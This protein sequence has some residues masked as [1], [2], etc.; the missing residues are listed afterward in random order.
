MSNQ[1]RIVV[2]A[3]SNANGAT[4]EAEIHDFG[5]VGDG[6]T[7]D[8]AAFKKAFAY[9]DG[10]GGTLY[11]PEGIYCLHEE[12]TVPEGVTLLGDFRQ[13]TPEDPRAGGTILALY[14]RSCSEGNTTPFFTLM[15]AASLNGL[16]L[17]YPEQAF[18][19]GQ[20]TAYPYTVQT[21]FFPAALEN[22]YLVNAYDGI[23]QEVPGDYTIQQMVRGIY[24]TP[25]HKGF[26]FNRAPDSCR[27][28][29]F[30]FRP[31]WWLGCGLP[32]VPEEKVLRGWLLENAVGFDLGA[33]DWHFISDITIQG[34]CIGMRLSSAFGR[35]YNLDITGCR[36]CLEV[37]SVVPYGGQLTCAVLRADGGSDP[38]ALHIR[39]AR[40]ENGFSCHAVT[41]ESTGRYAVVMEDKAYL[42]L[43]DSSVKAAAGIHNKEGRFTACGTVFACTDRTADFGPAAGRC[44]LTNCTDGA[45][46]PL[47]QPD[48]GRMEAVFD[49]EN[50][51][52]R[53]D[54]EALRRTDA[55]RRVR[56]GFPVTRCLIPAAEYG[57]LPDGSDVGAAL[58]AALD[59]ARDAGGGVVY[60]PAGVYRLES[61]VTVPSGVELRGATGHYHYVM[62]RCTYFLTDYGR[63][64]DTLP[65]LFTL[66]SGSGLRGI[67]VSYDKV[68]Q[69]TIQPYA[70][71]I[72]GRGSD[73]SVIG[74]SVAAAWFVADFNT[75]RCDNHYIDSL[76]FVAFHMGIAVGGGSENGV[77]LNGH[78]NPGEVWD[79]P[80]TERQNWSP[81]WDGP[82]ITHLTS[83]VTG[84]YVGETKNEVLY[85]TFIFGTKHGIH[86]D[87]GADV[88]VIGHGTDFSAHGVYLTGNS[89]S[90]IV[91][92]E[93]VGIYTTGDAQSNGV[94]A[95]ADFTGEAELFNVCPWNVHDAAVRVKNGTVRANGGV[96]FQ[97]G[98]YAVMVEKG[99]AVLSGAV[100][101]RC[102][103]GRFWASGEESTICAF[104]N[105]F[106]SHCCQ[107]EK[108]A[109]AI[110]SDIAGG[111]G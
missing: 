35:V 104:G 38:V 6:R 66:E 14:T 18:T 32:G 43:Q 100:L 39:G 45:G 31:D 47:V 34:Y 1:L 102:N 81:L 72:Q 30:D 9:M 69:E 40:E 82:L 91:D 76:N 97:S 56:T 83:H 65:A 92:A 80:F 98:D 79:N 53:L 10:C 20:P 48:N 84:F 23:N 96:F 77:V 25:L 44:R 15:G 63:G 27:Q 24:G 33:I 73:I 61:P 21:T 110:G 88:T 105:L 75:F 62:G 86:I 89:R 103:C 95:D 70:T 78:S 36:T 46:Q 12:L 28:H 109:R 29:G 2:S 94:L 106:I 49:P 3:Y 85:M 55:A 67:S 68:R 52:V 37:E 107:A 93:L 87:D 17:W 22:L 108:G 16:T 64:G 4:A 19:S 51:N 59:A 41:L 90:T 74:V 7:D 57:V 13:P 60:V 50:D 58:Q 8:T 54:R 71:T 111:H 26:W 99:H 101:M 42:T 11:I 5:A